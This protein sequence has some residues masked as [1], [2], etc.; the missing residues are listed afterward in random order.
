MFACLLVKYKSECHVDLLPGSET[1][2]PTPGI[3]PE[4]DGPSVTCYGGVFQR[5]VCVP[6]CAQE[7]QG[8][9]A[10]LH[11]DS[12]VLVSGLTHC[13]LPMGREGT[14]YELAS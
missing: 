2:S 7:Q 11:R 8:R 5:A 14:Y 9:P 10:P 1:F 12:Q 6:S 13:E 3:S 4:A